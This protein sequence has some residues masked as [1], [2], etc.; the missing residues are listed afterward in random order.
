MREPDSSFSLIHPS[1]S[2][3][4][5]CGAGCISGCTGRPLQSSE[6]SRPALGEPTVGQTNASP[7]YQ[8]TTTADG[9]CG[10]A[11]GGTA[12]GDW[13]NGS[14]CSMYGWCGNTYESRTFTGLPLKLLTRRTGL[15]I[16]DR[17]V[18]LDLA[19][20]GLIFRS[21]DQVQPPQTQILVPSVS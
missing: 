2:T 20:Y 21:Q 1:G 10:K 3:Q 6:A 5:H 9:T 18:S 8:D 15:V 16:V 19:Q 14:C 12:C 17:A 7:M 11:F 4:D 13:P